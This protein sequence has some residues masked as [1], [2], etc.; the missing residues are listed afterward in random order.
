LENKDNITL[1]KRIPDF[2]IIL[3]FFQKQFRI[4]FSFWEEWINSIDNSM[5]KIHCILFVEVQAFR[6][7]LS[8]FLCFLHDQKQ[9]ITLF[10][11]FAFRRK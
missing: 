2:K 9:Q 10:D 3:F 8:L 7:S 11:L 6:K 4:T 1:T 5:T